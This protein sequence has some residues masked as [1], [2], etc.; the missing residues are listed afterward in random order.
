MT[1]TIVNTGAVILGSCIGMILKKGLAE[2]Y[3]TVFFQV[4]GIITICLGITMVYNMQNT[5]IVIASLISGALLG[6]WWNIEQK[7][8]TIG[9]Y[10]KKK[11]T[12]GNARFSEG[13]ITAFLLFCMGSMTFLGTIQEGTG[14][15]SDLL[16]TK[17][18]LDLFSSI[19]L[20]SVFGIAI[21][22][23][24]VPLFIFQ[25][26][27]TLLAMQTADFMSQEIINGLTSVGG[28][29]LIALGIDILGLKKMNVANILP[30][31]VIVYII[32]YI[33]K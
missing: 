20:A 15:S 27:I 17:S 25:A 6:T 9:D 11:L 18:L 31:I 29:M 16:Y 23:S 4:V 8:T 24:A 12:I 7:L 3:Q 14:V 32:L 21:L 1:G 5:I 30:A 10:L 13:I 26:G 22:F 28:A 33:V 2:K 19:I